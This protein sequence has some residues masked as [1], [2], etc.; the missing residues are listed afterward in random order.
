MSAAETDVS[1]ALTSKFFNIINGGAPSQTTFLSLV[2]VGYPFSDEDLVFLE[3][4]TGL[5]QHPDQARAF[6]VLVDAIPSAVGRWNATNNPIG[7]AYRNVWLQLAEVPRVRL[8]R[9]QQDQLDEARKKIE[10]LGEGYVKYREIYQGALRD[11][12][13]WENIVPRPPDYLSE[14]Q[15]RKDAMD[16]AYQD[17]IDVGDK[18]EYE[19]QSAIK[20]HLTSLGY[21]KIITDLRG[22]YDGVLK[23]HFDSSSSMFS[24]QKTLFLKILK[25]S[26][27]FV[28]CNL[29]ISSFD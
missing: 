13:E 5:A 27:L 18:N 22:Q 17:W 16:N 11:V 6:S 21:D 8:T 3:P 29:F 14:L 15:K 7:S 23:T 12:I 10:E 2:D 26:S 20:A 25:R 9:D 28:V 19:T 4:G 1:T 24:I